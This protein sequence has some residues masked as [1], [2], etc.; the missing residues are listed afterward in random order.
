MKNLIKRIPVIGPAA[1][2]VYRR[3]LSPPKPFHGSEDYWI[4]RYR[5]GGNS[6]AGSYNRLAE[7]KAE[8][9][10]DFVATYHIQDVIEFGCGDGNQ[11]TLANYPAYLG[12]DV[13]PHAIAGCKSRFD[14]D[15]SKSFS[16]VHDYAG[17]MA[18]LA[19]S[20][21]VIYHL[22]EDEVFATYMRTLFGAARDYVVI[23]SSDK[24]EPHTPSAHVRHRQFSHW[25]RTHAPGWRLLRHIPNRYPYAGDNDTGSLADFYIYGRGS[26][27]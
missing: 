6:G 23:Y 7:F 26:L 12:L 16:L 17:Q 9:L 3:W 27:T 10:N 20:L 15:A 22:T 11:L 18:Q 5:D 14:G 25:V 4:E 1:Q 2:N 21:D 8:V 24:D 19:M 13:S